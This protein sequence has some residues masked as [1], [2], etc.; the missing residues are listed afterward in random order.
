VGAPIRK[1]PDHRVA[2]LPLHQRHHAILVPATD[3]RVDLPVPDAA[4]AL[5]RSRAFRDVTLPHEP[6]ATVVAVLAFA[7]QLRRLPEVA[8]EAPALELVLP[9]ISIDGFVA[10]PQT[11]IAT[12][13]A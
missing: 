11:T 5:H 2:R 3:D 8:I 10:D 1:F 6:S 13:P 9:H 7:T 12:Q 4:T